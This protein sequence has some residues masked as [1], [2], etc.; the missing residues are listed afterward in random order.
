MVVREPSDCGTC[1]YPDVALRRGRGAYDVIRTAHV[2]V[3]WAGL[4]GRFSDQRGSW[5]G[6]ALHQ[7]GITLVQTVR[8]RCAQPEAE[9]PDRNLFKGSE[10]MKLTWKTALI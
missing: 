7:R 10:P 5:Q 2:T 9:Y 1:S 3:T 8:Y 6:W 4:P